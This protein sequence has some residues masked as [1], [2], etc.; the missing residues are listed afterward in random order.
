M[1]R[2]AQ[3]S[4]ATAPVLRAAVLSLALLAGCAAPEPIAQYPSLSTDQ[5]LA[6]LRNR[7]AAIHDVAAQG[8]LTLTR[9]GGQTVRLDVALA[10]Q[11]SDRAR[12]RA[13]KLG[14]AVFD[15][16]ATPAGVW[17]IEPSPAPH[18]TNTRPSESTFDPTAAAATRQ[19]LALL[20]GAFDWSS[21]AVEVRPFRLIVRQRLPNG[22]ILSCSIDRHTLTPRQYSVWTGS[23]RPAFTLTLTDYATVNGIPWPRQIIAASRSGTVQLDLRDVQINA[24]LAPAALRPP[25]RAVRVIGPVAATEPAS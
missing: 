22:A 25:R 19:W 13:W 8:L 12:L 24:G 11:P 7:S 23:N 14:Q 9:P 6:V 3:R 16:T 18:T 10:M 1:S 2:S 5:S 17:T 15:L 20:G 21:A 4:G